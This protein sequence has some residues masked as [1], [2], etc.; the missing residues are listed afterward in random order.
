MSV[1]NI[2]RY[3]IRNIKEK[4]MKQQTAVEWLVDQIKSD[5]NQ[6][7]LSASEW[8]EVIEKAK[9]MEK[10]QIMDA[11]NQGCNDYDELGHKRIEQ[12]YNEKYGK[13]EIK[14]D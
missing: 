1:A 10:E 12:Y 4:P 14:T 5:Q 9:Q 8:M 13:D 7:A 2:K 3:A 11:Y 6:K